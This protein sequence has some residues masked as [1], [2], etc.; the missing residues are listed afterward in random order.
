[1][2]EFFAARD[3]AHA[4]GFAA[5]RRT[6]SLA[7]PSAAG[8]T[9]ATA[10]TATAALPGFASAAMDGWAVNGDGPWML[11]EPI[12]AGDEI[13]TQRL[14]PGAARPISTGA[15]L[16]PDA[17]RGIRSERGTLHGRTLS[18]TIPDAGHHVRGIAEEASSGDLLLEAGLRLSA[19]RL[20]LA[21]AAGYDRLAV[22]VPPATHLLVLGDEVVPAG[23]PVPGHVRDVFT[24]ALPAVLAQLGAESPM[25][26]R[27]GDSLDDTTAA[28][29]ATNAALVVTTGGSARGPAD[30]IRASLREHDAEVLLD[31]VRMRPGHPLLLARLA[32]GTVVLCLPGNPLAA[33][34]GAVVIGGALLDGMLGRPLVPLERVVLA[35][36]VP[37]CPS[38]RVMA[39]VRTPDGVVATAHQGAGMLRG[40]AIAELFAIVAPA[41]AHA[42][43]L[44][45]SIA[46]PW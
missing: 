14:A 46:L 6:E 33:F 1:M 37:A 4:V 2:T 22:V 35:E 11:G 45:P 26:E 41:G 3:L 31:G 16:P 12:K 19:P 7:L 36:A 29:A 24:P 8:R 21:A 9:L 34:V 13:P 5:A 25:L 40:L 17:A 27:V 18:E 30:H 42:G 32:S 28:L 43:D 44:V 15:P 38:T 39:A 20:A 10:I 23:R